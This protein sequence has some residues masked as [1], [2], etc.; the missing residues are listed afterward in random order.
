MLGYTITLAKPLKMSEMKWMGYFDEASK[1]I[2]C[3]KVAGYGW[4]SVLAHEFRHLEQCAAN[5]KVW[6]EFQDA[7]AKTPIMELIFKPHF[8]KRIHFNPKYSQRDIISFIDKW[9]AMERD[10]EV[11]TIKLLKEFKI[12]VDL[13]NYA[14]EVNLFLYRCEYLKYHN[15]WPSFY[16]KNKKTKYR[17]YSKALSLCADKI[18]PKPKSIPDELEV[19]FEK[20]IRERDQ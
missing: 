13:V 15:V 11:K 18:I 9:A 8:N 6:R 17:I 12:P 5:I 7:H 10:C 4:I 2:M 3:Y 19:I 20:L 16:T 14:K 1:S